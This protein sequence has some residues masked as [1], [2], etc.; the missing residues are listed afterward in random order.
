M[1]PREGWTDFPEYNSLVL[2]QEP[3]YWAMCREI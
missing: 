1:L 3:L 2:E